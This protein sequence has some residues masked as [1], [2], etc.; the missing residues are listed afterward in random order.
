[1]HISGRTQPPISL[2]KFGDEEA[3]KHLLGHVVGVLTFFAPFTFPIPAA[4]KKFHSV[5]VF[6]GA[7]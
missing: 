7:R 1:M 4:V 2:P 3:K 6:T 5:T